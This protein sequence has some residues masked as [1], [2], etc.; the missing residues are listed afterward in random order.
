M[1]KELLLYNYFSNQLTDDQELVFEELL[2]T[3]MDF[4]QQLDFEKDL[5][6]VIHEKEAVDLKTK[7]SGFEKEITK[8]IEDVP[9]RTLPRNSYRKWAM[10]ASIALLVGL[11]WFGYNNFAGPNYGNLYEENFQQYPNTVY[12]ITRGET[13]ESIERAAF[14]AYEAGNYSMAIDNFNK[15][16]RSEENQYL[17][18]YMGQAHLGLGEVD[19][20]KTFFSNAISSNSEFIAEAHWYLALIAIKEKDNESAIKSLGILT[21]QYEFKKD[22]ALKLLQELK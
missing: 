19:D 9:V 11:G 13:V 21:S 4:K 3:D 10:A 8:D 18:F 16:P 22:D 2:K 6:R 20:A 15:I 17:E 14:S 1:D 7:L 5:K 12:A